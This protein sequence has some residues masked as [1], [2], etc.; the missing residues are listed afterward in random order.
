[1]LRPRDHVPCN[2]IREMCKLGEKSIYNTKVLIWGEVP[3][4]SILCRWPRSRIRK[5]GLLKALPSFTKIKPK[6]KLQDLRQQIKSDFNVFS[7]SN[8]AEALVFLGMEPRQL[9]I[10]Q[11]FLFLLGQVSSKEVQKDL[12][13]VGLKL[14]VEFSGIIREFEREAHGIVV[15]AGREEMLSYYNDDCIHS[16]M[17]SLPYRGA[18]KFWALCVDDKFCPSFE[19]WWVSRVDEIS[20]QWERED[21][22]KVMKSNSFGLLDWVED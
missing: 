15:A 3:A 22:L 14:E 19:S 18:R 2:D 8:V 21:V 11:V 12:K 17:F 1:M 13:G 16:Y 20:S 7:S 4:E 9:D 5:S 6:M 10:K